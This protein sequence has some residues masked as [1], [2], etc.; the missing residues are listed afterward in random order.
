MT[1]VFCRD[2]KWISR[3]PDGDVSTGAACLHQASVAS[4]HLVTGEVYGGYMTAEDMRSA[5]P[6]AWRQA[7]CGLN[8]TLFEPREP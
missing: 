3:R 7:Y 4:V 1:D 6:N 2:C 8:G 5:R